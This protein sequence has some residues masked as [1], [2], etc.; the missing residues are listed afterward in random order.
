MHVHKAILN[1]ILVLNVP[2]YLGKS[3]TCVCKA[4]T[5]QSVTCNDNQ[6]DAHVMNLTP[7]YQQ[8]FSCLMELFSLCAVVYSMSVMVTKPTEM[9]MLICLSVRPSVCP[10]VCLSVFLYVFQSI[11]LSTHLSHLLY[12]HF[13]IIV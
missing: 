11:Y 6:I 4:G 1:H 3:L 7:E 10:S 8:V 12:N 9:F 13:C 5:P 2:V